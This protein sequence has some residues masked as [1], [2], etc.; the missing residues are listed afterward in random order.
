MIEGM[1]YIVAVSTVCALAGVLVGAL[2]Q[3]SAK[4]LYPTDWM[5]ITLAIAVLADLIFNIAPWEKFWYAPFAAGF[6]VGYLLVGRQ[7][8]IIVANI[9]V[10]SKH[11]VLRPWVMYDHDGELC[12][13][14]QKN[15]DLIR[16]QFLGIHNHV[17]DMDGD[18]PQISPD[19]I[20]NAKYPLFPKFVT[21]MLV[22]EDLAETE[23]TRK[24]WWRI[25][26]RVPTTYICVA[27][28]SSASKLELMRSVDI[29]TDQQDLIS[30]LYGEIHE[31]R[32]AQGPKLMEMAI[33]INDKATNTSPENRMYGLLTREDG[34]VRS[35]R[36]ERNRKKEKESEDYEE[37]T[38]EVKDVKT[39]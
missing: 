20:S 29:L 34:E 2:V 21:T 15:R 17:L 30:R 18:P 38:E 8:Y 5:S 27:F 12:R 9:N 39:E 4:F 14:R 24:I 31:L 1:G 10:A 25:K 11:L 28:A 3:R 13:Q 32:S 16:R 7:K 33:R 6:A 26:A 23:E 36:E 35:T 22:L 19:W 37:E